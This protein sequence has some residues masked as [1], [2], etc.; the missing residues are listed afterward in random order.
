M[1][2]K[3]IDNQASTDLAAGK[4]V[5]KIGAE[6]L[7]QVT[8]VMGAKRSMRIRWRN[9]D[10]DHYPQSS[11]PRDTAKYL[12][13]LDPYSA[14]YDPKTR[15]MRDAHDKAVAPEEVYRVQSLH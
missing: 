7:A 1:S 5:A 15:S 14:Y 11:Y 13:N 2:E 6:I 10:S 12:I 9:Q 8:R 4:K 3:G